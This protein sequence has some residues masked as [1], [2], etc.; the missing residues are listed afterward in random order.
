MR[1]VESKVKSLLIIFFDMK[2][3]VHKEFFLA[4]QSIPCTA[5]I[6]YGDCMKIYKDFA[7]NFGNKRTGCCIMT[8][9]HLKLPFSPGSLD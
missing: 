5:V 4:G 1:Q 6:F 8:T 2:R 9:H 3:I 7:P